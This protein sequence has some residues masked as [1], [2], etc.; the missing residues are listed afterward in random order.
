MKIS[1]SDLDVH[2]IDGICATWLNIEE[3]TF[4]LYE[5][6]EGSININNEAHTIRFKLAPEKR[7]NEE[8]FEVII[9]ENSDNNFTFK[10][11]CY[12]DRSEEFE[13]WLLRGIDQFLFYTS[14]NLEE[15]YFHINFKN[16]N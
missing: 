10:A 3:K 6:I 2:K 5:S 15:I 12:E 7:I 1:I 4:C 16:D 14:D 11:D 13:I 9:K 8:P